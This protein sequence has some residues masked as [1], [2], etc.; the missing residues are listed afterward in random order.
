[1]ALSQKVG[2]ASLR[3]LVF[4]VHQAARTMAMEESWMHTNLTR[5]TT[6]NISLTII[7][8]SSSSSLGT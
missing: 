5:L 8:H 6:N 1:M 4:L 7:M 3:A 2:Q